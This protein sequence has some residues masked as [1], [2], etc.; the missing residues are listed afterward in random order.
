MDREMYRKVKRRDIQ[1]ERFLEYVEK[2]NILGMA[3]EEESQSG[4]FSASVG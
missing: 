4:T 1:F 2:P 3:S